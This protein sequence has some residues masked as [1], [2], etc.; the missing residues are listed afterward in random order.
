VTGDWEGHWGVEWGLGEGEITLS[1]T[2]T[3]A[4]GGL[5]EISGDIAAG[6]NHIEGDFDVSAGWC[7][8][9]ADGDV[10]LDRR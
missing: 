5:V 8:L 7:G 2:Q 9:G 10:D 4:G 6:A 3:D 1:L